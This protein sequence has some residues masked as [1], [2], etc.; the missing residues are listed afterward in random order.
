MKKII[1][2]TIAFLALMIC[3]PVKAETVYQR[4]FDVLKAEALQNPA[5]TSN[6][7]ISPLFAPVIMAQPVMTDFSL[8]PSATTSSQKTFGSSTSIP[9]TSTEATSTEATSTEATSIPIYSTYTFYSNGAKIT[10]GGTSLWNVINT[11]YSWHLNQCISWNEYE[12]S[13][14]DIYEQGVPSIVLEKNTDPVAY[15][16]AIQSIVN[17]CDQEWATTTAWL[18]NEIWIPQ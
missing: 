1:T 9:A 16:N 2:I 10:G 13:G 5:T 14:N 11:Y 15:T 12:I 6:D 7:F 8:V 18:G 3:L 4:D 17:Q